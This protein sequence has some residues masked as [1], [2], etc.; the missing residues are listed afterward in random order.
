MYLPLISTSF[1]LSLFASASD[2]A[3][4]R[5]KF[6]GNTIRYRRVV[7]AAAINRNREKTK[8][9]FPSFAMSVPRRSEEER[10]DK[11]HFILDA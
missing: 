1:S 3:I 11:R 9:T 2:L 10:D 7:S 8:E 4:F 5:I 6:T